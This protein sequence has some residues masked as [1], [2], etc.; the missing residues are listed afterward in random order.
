MI[1]LPVLD[2]HTVYFVSLDNVLWALNRSTRAEDDG[3]EKALQRH[4]FY[5][6]EC[7]RDAGYEL[8]VVG[9]RGAGISK[10]ILGSAATEL[11]R[12]SAVPVL[13]VGG[14]HRSGHAA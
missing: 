11:A 13:V 7:A 8:I 12:N 3:E 6:R 4:G 5:L 9:S 2:E 1:G 10:A 14:H